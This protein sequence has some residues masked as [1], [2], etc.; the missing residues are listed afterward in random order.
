MMNLT[1][2]DLRLLCTAFVLGVARWEEKTG[3]LCFG[4]LRYGGLHLYGPDAEMTD[5]VRAR[6]RDAV[7]HWREHTPRSD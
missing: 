7:T 3:E 6:L 4:G 1:P 5:H 2:S